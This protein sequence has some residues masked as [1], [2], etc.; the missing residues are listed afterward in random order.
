MRCPAVGVVIDA[1]G[2]YRLMIVRSKIALSSED[3]VDAIGVLWHT[4][5]RVLTLPPA[6]PEAGQRH[7]PGSHDATLLTSRSR[8]RMVIQAALIG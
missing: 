6:R 5:E 2:D 4:E 1:G 7:V 3:D 8:S